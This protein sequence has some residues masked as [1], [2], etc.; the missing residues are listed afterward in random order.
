MNSSTTYLEA[1]SR[2]AVAAASVQRVE[3]VLWLLTDEIV[4]DLGFEDC[5]VY[6]ADEKRE[7][8]RQVAAFGQ[9]SPSPHVISNPIELRFGQGITGRAASTAESILVND[10]RKDPD[11]VIDDQARLS[12]LA[13]PIVVEGQVIGVIDSEHSELNFYT[14]EH[15]FT[16]EAL[17]SLI[18]AKYQQARLLTQL[19]RSE[20]EALY[21]AAHDSLT[22]LPNR[23]QFLKWIQA[24]LSLRGASVLV[25][26]DLDRF[27]VINDR[28]GHEAGDDLLI[29]VAR[30]FKGAIPTNAK[31]ARLSGDEF[32][33]LIEGEV[34]EAKSIVNTMLASLEEPI[35]LKADRVNIRAS[36]GMAMMDAMISD[37]SSWLRRADAMLYQQKATRESGL[38]VYGEDLHANLSLQSEL[39]VEIETAIAEKQFRVALQPIVRLR[40][41]C[42][43]GAEALIRWIH[44]NHGFIPPNDF[45]PSA[46][47]SGQVKGIDSCVVDLVGQCFQRDDS[48]SYISINLSPASLSVLNDDAVLHRLAERFG[49][50]LRVE[51]TERAMIANFELAAAGLEH[52]RSR[53]VRVLLDD[54]GTGY[55]SLSYVH[56]LP[57]DAL[58]IDQSFV[59]RLGEDKRSESLIRMITALADSLS[60]DVIAEG[61]ETE[62]QRDLLKGLNVEFGQGYLFGKPALQA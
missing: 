16:L 6:L 25:L 36:A 29:A 58:K 7:I 11:Y 35:Q 62:Q 52:L 22:G 53:G 46:E 28:F 18:G 60:L 57:V 4:A 12:E 42:A 44:P 51:V 24:K 41:G 15:Q 48:D 59:A 3:E 9:K 30:R 21:T 40:D 56:R 37:A 27:K 47:R 50:R 17:A 8:L 19:K 31:L 43:V 2:F 13:V 20:A 32:A 1:L 33:C 45:I 5:V 26:L 23:A 39:D 34:D 38:M 49:S 10:V 14:Q 54:F 61:I 55:S